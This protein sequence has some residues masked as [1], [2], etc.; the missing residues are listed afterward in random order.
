MD[1]APGRPCLS[2]GSCGSEALVRFAV[3]LVMSHC[4]SFVKRP[5]LR[6]M[7]VE[8]M[9][10]YDRPVHHWSHSQCL[11]RERDAKSPAHAHFSWGGEF[12]AWAASCLAMHWSTAEK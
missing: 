4:V 10:K 7:N 11:A 2:Y 8:Q 5:R 3:A 6:E 9:A 1:C 12:S